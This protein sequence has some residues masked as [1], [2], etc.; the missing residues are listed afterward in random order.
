MNEIIAKN[1]VIGITQ[2][3]ELKMEFQ[4]LHKYTVHNIIS[5]AGHCSKVT[6]MDAFIIYKAA[7]DEPINLKYIMLKEIADIRNH[8]SRA[9][10]YGAL[11]TKVFSHF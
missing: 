7:I 4:L 3:K 10:P 9:L 5:K 1:G 8:S 2:T 11:L 6:N